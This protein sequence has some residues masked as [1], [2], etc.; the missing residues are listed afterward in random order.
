MTK[1]TVQGGI[2]RF[3]KDLILAALIFTAAGCAVAPSPVY[4]IT[5]NNRVWRTC[6]YKFYYSG[7]GFY[8]ENG[9]W[10]VIEGNFV[11]ERE[12]GYAC[13]ERNGHPV[14]RQIPILEPNQ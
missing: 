13:V 12:D 7:M 11:F 6:F 5:Q 2:C 1:M 3:A 9:D 14:P 10:I 4:R 8:D